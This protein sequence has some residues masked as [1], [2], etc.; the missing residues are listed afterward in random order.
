M[1]PGIA[2]RRNAYLEANPDCRNIISLGIGD[3]TQVKAAT[4]DTSNNIYTSISIAVPG[5]SVLG[6]LVYRLMTLLMSCAHGVV[7]RY[8]VLCCISCGTECSWLLGFSVYGWMYASSKVLV[9]HSS[10]A[11]VLLNS[12]LVQSRIL[13]YC[14]RAPRQGLAACWRS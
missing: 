11:V 9:Q 10:T 7:R 5:T 6:Y 13:G 4:Y 2:K 1:F 14:C 12:I 3:T 8:G